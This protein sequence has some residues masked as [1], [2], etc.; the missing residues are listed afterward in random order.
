MPKNDPNLPLFYELLLENLVA[1]TTALQITVPDPTTSTIASL[2][3]SALYR[4]RVRACQVAC[5]SYSSPLFFGLGLG[6]VPLTAPVISA[7]TVSGGNSLTVTWNAVV[8][9]DFYRLEVVQ[10]TGGP[11]GGALTVAARQISPTT[12]TL[13]V[14]LG[15]ANVLVAACNGDGCGPFSAA[16]AIS[17]P[18]PNPAAPQLG[19][20]LAGSTVAGPTTLFSWSRVPGDVGS[21]SY[22]L[23]VQDLSRQQAA[24]D[25]VTTQNFWAAYFKAEG[26]R[27]D[28]LVVADPSGA[29]PVTGPAQ[30]FNMG[31]TSSTAPTM[32]R[33]AHQSSLPAG[34][35]QLAWSPVPGATLYEYFVAVTGLPSATARGVTPGLVVQ[36]P[37]PLVGG[38]STFYS[39]IVRACPAGAN[40]V[41]GSDSGWG[42][43]SNVGGPGVT[44][45]QVTP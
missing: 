25:V 33:P 35:I 16:S 45:F 9:A 13:P 44:S 12:V 17:P 8:G 42:P 1:G 27:Y 30:G 26:S 24:L 41:A 5:G 11:G 39:G 2:A 40:C 21:T 15:N 34:N 37:L 36:V 18:G 38:L 28:A 10:P 43:W 4:L 23:F 32:V 29:S 22:R 19:S 31:G 14:P 3:S 20:P 7:A 6:P